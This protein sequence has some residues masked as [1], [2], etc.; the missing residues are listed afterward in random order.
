MIDLAR[1]SGMKEEEL[2]N[3]FP[4]CGLHVIGKKEELVA[5]VFVAAENNVPVQKTAEEVQC[6]IAGASKAKLWVSGI[7]ILD[8]L[9]WTHGWLSEEDSI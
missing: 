3:L 8:P 5:R 7:Q 1:I 9:T 2:K 4:L 6:Q